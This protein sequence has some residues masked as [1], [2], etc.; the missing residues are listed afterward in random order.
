MECNTIKFDLSENIG[1][2]LISRPEALNALNSDVFR[3]LNQ[4]L[5]HISSLPEVK[6]VIITGSGR[7]FVAG[8][9]I[10]EMIKKNVQDASQFGLNGQKTFQ[11]IEQFPLPVIAA[12]NGFALGGGC[13]LAMACDFR[14]ASTKAKFGQPEVNLGLIPGFAGTQRLPRLVGVG[15]ALKMLMT[16]EMITAEDALRVGLVQEVVEPEQLIPRVREIATL[17]ISKGPNAIAFVKESVRKGMLTGFE[18]G[19]GLELDRFA[20]LFASDGISGMKAFLEKKTPEW[21]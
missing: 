6:I 9:D 19:C 10:A 1:T 11:R 4:V 13:E 8:A 5:D 12:V 14:I 2:I 16:A 20:Q 21:K 17:I 3:D 7:A 18:A 15:N